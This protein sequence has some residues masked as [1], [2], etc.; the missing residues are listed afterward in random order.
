[1]R[2]IQRYSNRKLYDRSTKSYTSLRRILDLVRLGE[3]F[4]V[5]NHKAQDITA[6]TL[7]R[8]LF[9]NQEHNNVFLTKDVLINLIRGLNV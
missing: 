6:E 8:A 7:S 9:E 3:A 2:R 1:M 5:T 4:E